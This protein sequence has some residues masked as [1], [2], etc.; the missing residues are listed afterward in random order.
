L[1]KKTK[2]TPLLPNEVALKV[3]LNERL[4]TILREE[5]NRLFQ[6]AKVKH[7]LEGDD[8]TNTSYLVANGKHRK[9]RIYSLED[10]NGVRIEEE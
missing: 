1:D 10:D 9:Q 5:E 4:A 7:L 8:N 6:R 2:T 3:Y